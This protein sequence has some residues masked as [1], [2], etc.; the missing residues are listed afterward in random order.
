LIARRDLLSGEEIT[1]SYIR[2]D[3]LKDREERRANLLKDFGFNC[4]CEYCSIPPEQLRASES[5]LAKLRDFED[6]Y[7]PE[8]SET[9]IISI[10]W[11]RGKALELLDQA[12]EWVKLEGLHDMIPTMLQR[13]AMVEACWG[14]R[15]EA[16]EAAQRASEEHRI[17]LGAWRV[18]LQPAAL[19]SKQP[20][21]FYAWEECRKQNGGKIVS[22]LRVCQRPLTSCSR[23]RTMVIR[24]LRVPGTTAKG[25]R[26][27]K[28]PRRERASS[29]KGCHDLRDISSWLVCCCAIEY[30]SISRPVQRLSHTVSRMMVWMLRVSMVPFSKPK[31]DSI[32][33]VY[34]GLAEAP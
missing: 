20:E 5:R 10:A 6:K 21:I 12:T 33:E 18:A 9:D 13:R 22:Q 29:G 16:I 11:D 15:K 26:K 8:E 28:R 4:L 14:N 24:T 30:V 7:D 32:R 23:R 2:P 17:L 27:R 1:A 3:A 31:L 19:W 25:E 34:L